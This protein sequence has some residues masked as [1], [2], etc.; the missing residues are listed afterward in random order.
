MK[1]GA[2]NAS[3][4]VGLGMLGAVVGGLAWEVVE[5][6]CLRFGMALE[7][8]IGPIGFDFSVISL[9]FMVNPGTFIGLCAGVVLF[10]FL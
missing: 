4:L 3:T 5:R 2:K 1:L 8:S 7:M 9:H 6:I 10:H